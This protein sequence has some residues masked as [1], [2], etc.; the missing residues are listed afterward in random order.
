VTSRLSLFLACLACVFGLAGCGSSASSN[1]AAP[2]P[3]DYT[4][5]AAKAFTKY[6]VNTLNQA[7]TSGKTEQLLALSGPKCARCKDFA[8]QLKQIYSAGGHVETKGWK[9]TNVIPIAGE[10]LKHPGFQVV[11]TVS[12]QKVYRSKGAKPQTYAG[13]HQGMRMFL[14]R[15]GDQWQVA[16][17]EIAQG[18]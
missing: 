13:G 8:Q 11:A 12:P 14:T 10:N 5:S 3:S 4:V 1:Q 18:T 9:V 6:W 15:A 17:I 2:P 16:T 7:T